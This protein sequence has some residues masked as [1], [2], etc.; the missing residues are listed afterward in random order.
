[1]PNITYLRFSHD[2]S[3]D[4]FDEG[5]PSALVKYVATVNTGGID[6]STI[7]PYRQ[8]VELTLTKHFD[9]GLGKISAG[10]PG[11]M[12]RRTE[13]G[14]NKNYKVEPIFEELDYFDPVMYLQTQAEESPLIWNIITFPIITSDNDQIENYIF[15]GVIEPLTIRARASFFSID[16]PFESR[17]VHGSVMDGN[18]DQSLATDQVCTVY[19]WNTDESLVEFLDMVDMIDGMLP[20]NGYFTYEKT[21]LTPFVDTRL[22]RNTSSSTQRTDDFQPALSM[23]TGSTDNYINHKQ[24]SA[25]CGWTYDYTNTIGT[26]SLAFGGFGY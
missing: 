14:Q 15:D 11:H 25:T 21:Y 9:A 13:Y 17:A 1:V 2:E 7:D 8:G 26:D 23:M 18:D 24:R 16:V 4:W 3:P 10:E 22:V 19:E 6:M 20:L 5:P 12:L